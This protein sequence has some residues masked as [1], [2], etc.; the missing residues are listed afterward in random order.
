[1]LWKPSAA[2]QRV[3]AER[4]IFTHTPF[5]WINTFRNK[6]KER[7]R[8]I[9]SDA[10]RERRKCASARASVCQR[11]SE[12]GEKKRGMRRGKEMRRESI[13]KESLPALLSS[14]SSWFETHV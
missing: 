6:E 14:E 12:R 5:I 2:D 1:M 8:Q 10:W 13:Y 3:T 9:E 4:N 11:K 7:M